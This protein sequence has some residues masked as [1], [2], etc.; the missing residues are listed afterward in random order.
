MHRIAVVAV[1]ALFVLGSLVPTPHGSVGPQVLTSV[2]HSAPSTA[3]LR[4]PNSAGAR[5]SSGSSANSA[6]SWPTYMYDPERTGANHFENTIAPSNVAHLQELWSVP[7][8][9]SDYSAPI[10]IN[11]TV[12]YGSWN[13]YEYA[14]NA[15]N[16]SVEWTQYLGVAPCISGGISSTPAYV[17]GT[18]Y[19]GGGDGY[20][21]ALN[22]ANGSVEWRVLAGSQANNYNDWASALVYHNSVYIG[23]ASCYDDPLIWGQLLE[24]NLTGNHAVNHTFDVVPQGTIGGSIWTTPA[25]DPA[26]NTVWVTTGNEESG[27]PPYVNAIIGLNA[28]TLSLLGSWQVPNVQGQ[29]SDFGSTPN[30]FTTTSGLSLVV[31]TN[32]NGVSYAL[33]RSNVTTNGSWGPIWNLATGGGFSGGTFDGTTLY[34]AGSNLYAVD[35]S[36]GNVSWTTPL[37]GFVDGSLTWAN[38]LVYVGA[39]TD[40]E[41]VNATNGSVLW[42]YTLPGGQSI[43]TEP[44]VDDG[45]V[46]VASGNGGAAG[47]LTAFGL[48]FT[49]ESN[50]SPLTG[51]VP[52][53]VNFTATAEG[54]MTPYS[55]T[56]SFGD[57]TQAAGLSVSHTYLASGNYTVHVWINDSARGSFNTTLLVVALPSPVD[58]GLRA[59]ISAPITQGLAPLNVSLAGN[60]V[61][62]SQ[63]PYT[64][65]WNFGDGTVGA[66]SDV[67]HLYTVPGSYI[68][69]LQVRDRSG[70]VA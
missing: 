26:T 64:F 60:A 10:V 20:W 32:K 40:L 49:A 38:G 8:N 3:A 67:S 54:G 27:Y 39:G 55:A 21:Y 69:T 33:N 12:Y 41:A 7:S 23:L 46:Y 24:V 59:E 35:P 25:V 13:G 62:G 70:N 57:G 44:V 66:G 30:L 19:L 37:V 2:V 68:V 16:G 5:G 53:A 29:D 14:V 43:V 42:D 63:P 47:N 6:L 28:T 58:P 4:P 52:F 45:R 34:L 22:A 9:A 50:A 56:W 1:L 17:N 65:S 51:V 15:A 36:S 48:P 11:N 18:L 31:A 61:N